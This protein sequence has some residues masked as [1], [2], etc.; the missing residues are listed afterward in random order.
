MEA[1]TSSSM[2]PTTMA[3]REALRS[4][5]LCGSSLV[6]VAVVL[7]IP[8]TLECAFVSLE[9]V[10]SVTPHW[11]VPSVEDWGNEM[12]GR[13]RPPMAMRCQ[14]AKKEAFN[15]ISDC[16]VIAGTILLSHFIG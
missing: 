3:S 14:L 9:C 11:C 1:R 8:A 6:L 16:A 13:C 2:Y 12:G 7:S 5:A 10:Y 15:H 4:I